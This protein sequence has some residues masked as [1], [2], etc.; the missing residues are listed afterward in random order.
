[1]RYLIAA[2]LLVGCSS[3]PATQPMSAPLEPHPTP[4]REAVLGAGYVQE[5]PW[6]RG[7]HCWL[8]SNPDPRFGETSFLA[9]PAWAETTEVELVIRPVS[10]SQNPMP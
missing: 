8:L 7:E 4:F 1:M 9:I 5:G 6:Q 2:M 3:E 10:H